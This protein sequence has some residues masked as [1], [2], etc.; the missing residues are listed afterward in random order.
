MTSGTYDFSVNLE[1]IRSRLIW[2][3][4]LLLIGFGI[5]AT[6]Y[7]L[8]QR[9]IPLAAVG[10]PV[11]FVIFMRVVQVMLNDKPSYGIYFFVWGTVAHFIAALFIF[12]NPWLPYFAVPWVFISAML[13]RNGG[14][15]NTAIFVFVATLLNI[16]G[17]R[18]YPLLELTVLLTLSAG[19]SWISAYT[20]FSVVH[21][22]SAEQLHSQ[23]LLE[24]TRSHRASLSRALKS[25]QAAFEMQKHIQRELIWA[26]KHAEDARRLK[27]QFAANISH[28]LWTPLNLIVG[29]SEVMH[30]SPEVYGDVTWTPGLR[31]DI[32]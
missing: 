1:E 3:L 13:I 23:E 29:F 11:S 5:V 22:Y 26:R 18:S 28:E 10:I 7:V 31:R 21:W 17:V 12:D 4:S 16:T 30:L 9:D 32:H 20:L 2:R 25:L 27:E 6:W 19:S 14:L 8:L 24:T 15:I